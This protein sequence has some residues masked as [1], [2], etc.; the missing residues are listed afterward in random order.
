MTSMTP[1]CES[2]F[3]SQTCYVKRTA[4]GICNEKENC[5]GST[6]LGAERTTN[7]IVGATASHFSIGTEG[8]EGH[9]GEQSHGLADNKH[10]TV[11]GVQNG[12]TE[13]WQPSRP[14]QQ[15]M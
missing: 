13:G 2:A 12:Y 1:G 6:K 10:S 8:A 3:G 7:H 5:H 15:P 14:R 9:C 11:K 4:D